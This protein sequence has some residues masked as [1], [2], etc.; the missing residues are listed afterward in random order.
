MN[1][2]L[3]FEFL[4]FPIQLPPVPLGSERHVFAAH[5]AFLSEL[6]VKAYHSM[7]RMSQ[8]ERRQLVDV[9][10]AV[11]V[12]YGLLRGVRVRRDLR[13]RDDRIAYGS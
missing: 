12:E 4:L 9:L 8:S 13:D 11:A 3:D 1:I 6:L 7:P 10:P 5:R 2:Q